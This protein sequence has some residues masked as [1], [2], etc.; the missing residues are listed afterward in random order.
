MAGFRAR[1]EGSMAVGTITRAQCEAGGGTATLDRSVAT[2]V[3]CVGGTANGTLIDA[4]SLFPAPPAARP[5]DDRA[6]NAARIAVALIA[7]WVALVAIPG[8]IP[9]QATD[10]AARAL[11]A[12]VLVSSVVALLALIVALVL[13][14]RRRSEASA[15]VERVGVSVALIAVMLTALEVGDLVLVPA[16]AP[17]DDK[18]RQAVTGVGLL[19]L[20]LVA[21]VG[22]LAARSG[23]FDGF[24]FSALT[25]TGTLMGVA[26]VAVYLSLVQT[27]I[28][29]TGKEVLDAEWIRL[30]TLLNGLQTLAFA[31][32]GALLGTAVQGQVT[33][34]V[35]DD[36]GNADKAHA[37]LAVTVRQ[38]KS[39]AAARGD[40]ELASRLERSLESA[41]RIRLGQ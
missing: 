23:F 32:A 12:G 37:K 41:Q 26:L 7:S 13:G 20:L 22:V 30:T 18:F 29:K 38:V 16:L 21:A 9:W 15:Q 10:D 3:K 28:G 8:A 2:G 14:A 40:A 11:A 27:L 39:D 19:V 6:Q 5:A 34:K 25:L 24:K 4:A 36:L 17:A 33:K 1:L 35:S 31:A